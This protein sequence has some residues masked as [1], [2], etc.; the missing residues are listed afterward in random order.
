VTTPPPATTTTTL[1]PLP[2]A[3]IC[4]NCVDDDDDQ[5]IDAEDADCCAAPATMQVTRGRFLT[6]K[7][8]SQLKLA[9][10][11]A[12]A[13][14]A[15]VDPLTEDVGIQLRNASGELLC[16]TITHDRWRKKRKAFAFR[17]SAAGLSTVDL[18]VPKSGA[19]RFS[20]AG[21]QIDLTRFG[22]SPLT[23]TVRVGERCSRGSAALRQSKKGLL[24]P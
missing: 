21:K 6:G 24:F 10:V 7:K 15:A 23:V 8:G 1:P 18:K 4:G 19:V 22:G 17:G 13:G 2:L 14:F 16:T 5:A 20:A 9:A 12:T 11:L 3:E